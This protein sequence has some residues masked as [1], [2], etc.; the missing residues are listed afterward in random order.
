MNSLIDLVIKNG[1]II[2]LVIFMM[3]MAVAGYIT[4]LKHRL[5]KKEKQISE[6][7]EKYH[8]LDRHVLIMSHNLSLAL[9]RKLHKQMPSGEWS[10]SNPLTE[11]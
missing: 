10:T 2:D 4:I 1:S 5:D 7:K 11:D 3:G 9:K 8:L 6:L